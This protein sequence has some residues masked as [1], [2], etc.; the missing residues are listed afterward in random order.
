MPFRPFI[1]PLAAT[2]LALGLAGCA[3]DIA[4]ADPAAGAPADLEIRTLTPGTGGIAAVGQTVRVHYTGWLYD[5]RQ[6]GRKGAE[7]DSSRP[8]GEPFVFPLGSGRVIRGWDEGVLGMRIGEVRELAI[9]AHL[10]YGN[11]GAGGVIPPD[12]PLL[13]EVELLGIEPGP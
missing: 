2:L 1:A 6:P 3:P 7:F 9:P 11:R 5:E 4:P 8:R 10:A 12:Q 13:F